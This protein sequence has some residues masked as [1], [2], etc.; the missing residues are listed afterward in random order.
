MYAKVVGNMLSNYIA[1]FVSIIN[2]SIITKR[3]YCRVIHTNLG[4]RIVSLLFDKGYISFYR[5]VNSIS[6][7]YIYIGFKYELML[8]PLFQIK[9][10][11]KSGNY[12]YW[13]LKKL[14]QEHMDAESITDYLLTTSKGIIFSDRALEYG[15]GGKVL[16]KIN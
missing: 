13:S 12:I 7:R 16:F 6:N 9:L 4:V 3:N 1:N 14:I 5:F 11:S 15:I 2:Y 10:V 8:N